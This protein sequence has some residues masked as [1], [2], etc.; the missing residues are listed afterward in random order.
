[1]SGRMRRLVR[2]SAVGALMMA[3]A[4]S[5]TAAA[6]DVAARDLM[7]RVAARAEPARMMTTVQFELQA[8]NGDVQARTATLYRLIG[9]D[10]KKI[11]MYFS[12]PRG[13]RGSSFLSW[14]GQAP[15]FE[16]D[17]WLY[18]PALRRVRRVPIR[19]RGQAFLGTDLSYGDISLVAKLDPEEWRFESIEPGEGTTR[20][21]TASARDADIVRETGYS[22]ARWTVDTARDFPS[23]SEYWDAQGEP[24]KRVAYSD[25]ELRDGT[26]SADRIHVE[27]FKTGHRTRLHLTEVRVNAAATFADDLL[28][29][30]QLGRGP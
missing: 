30:A 6:D 11:A 14:N 2:L 8:R 20:V 12:L 9:K 24:L 13:I 10:Y 15:G 29:S 22:R 26:W 28:E 27:N 21:V 5:G 19:E 1:M 25:I 23:Q 4:G 3:A 7:T 17:Q 16:D 18:V